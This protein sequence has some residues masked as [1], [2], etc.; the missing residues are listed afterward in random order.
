[1]VRVETKAV[2]NA[3]NPNAKEIVKVV[4]EKGELTVTNVPVPKDVGK[5]EV[6]L[7]ATAAALYTA[8]SEDE[9]E[10]VKVGILAKKVKLEGTKEISRF[11]LSG[12]PL[13][14][15]PGVKVEMEDIFQ[16]FAPKVFNRDHA[17]IVAGS[18]NA[19]P[20]AVNVCS[21][22]WTLVLSMIVAIGVSL[23]T[24]PKPDA[25]LKNVVMGLTPRPDE[26]P[27]PW[28]K[29]PMLWAAVVFALIVLVNII[30]W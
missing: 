10:H 15:E 16:H 28:Y 11:G 8:V 1:M 3:E 13:V 22:F 5:V 20:M 30:F 14:V 9:G 19:Q 21:A 4:I 6:T 2:P 27:C 12:V 18:R 7:P 25:E 26:G 24:K 17:E 29:K 23:F